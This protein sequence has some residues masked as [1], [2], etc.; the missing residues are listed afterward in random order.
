MTRRSPP[1]WPTGPA[2]SNLLALGPGAADPLGSEVVIATPAV[3]AMFGNRL[4]TVYAPQALASF[5]TGQDRIDVRAVAP[6]GAGAYRT[7]LAA[8]VSARRAAGLQLLADPRVTAQP[9]ARADLAAGRVDARLLITLAAMARNEQVNVVSFGDS[10]PG[11]GPGTPLRSAE[12]TAPPVTAQ[13]MLAFVRAQRTP[14]LPI[15]SGLSRDP[16]G[17][18]VLSIEFSAPGLLGLL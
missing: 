1:C 8:D 13:E 4:A 18:T 14:Y 3:R 17:Q 2:S 9:S 6:D 10:G 11:A 15:R 12:L 5:G 16:D 7:A